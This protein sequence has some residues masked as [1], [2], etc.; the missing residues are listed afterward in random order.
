MAARKQREIVLVNRISDLE[1]GLSDYEKVGPS[2]D[3]H[4]KELRRVQEEAYKRGHTEAQADMAHL[5]SLSQHSI[6]RGRFRDSPAGAAVFGLG[7]GVALACVFSFTS[8][9]D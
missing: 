4:S 5:Q 3:T 8:G 9:P 1:R 2:W 7:V 6:D